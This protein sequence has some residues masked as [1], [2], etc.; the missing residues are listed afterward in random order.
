MKGKD[1][2]GRGKWVLY[3]VLLYEQGI[4]LQ[5]SSKSEVVVL[6]APKKKSQ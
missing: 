3:A 2:L 1:N 5:G 6:V 4:W